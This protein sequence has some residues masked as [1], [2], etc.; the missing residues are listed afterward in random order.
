[1]MLTD[2]RRWLPFGP[3]FFCQ[4]KEAEI[5]AA[6][7]IVRIELTPGAK[8]RLNEMSSRSGMTQVALLSRLVEWFANQRQLVQGGV[9]GHYPKEMQQELPSLI[10]SEI[11]EGR[12]RAESKKG[13]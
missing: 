9:L 1:M 8:D 6:R 5:M 11:V 13:Q 7:I 12:K 3:S 2:R 4:A 10:L